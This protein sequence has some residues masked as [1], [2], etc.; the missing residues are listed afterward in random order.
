MSKWTKEKKKKED[1]Y[2]Q[3]QDREN[4]GLGVR[5]VSRDDPVD[6]IIPS[7]LLF[8]PFSIIVKPV[9]FSS[10]YSLNAFSSSNYVNGIFNRNLTAL[11]VAIFL[12]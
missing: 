11:F 3:Q 1:A 6:L 4:L 12:T 5:A 7:P 2:N 9:Y 8:S 10:I